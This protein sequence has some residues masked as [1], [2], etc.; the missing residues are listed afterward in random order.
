MPSSYGGFQRS[1]PSGSPAALPILFGFLLLAFFYLA[2]TRRIEFRLEIFGGYVLAT[3][4]YLGTLFEVR[5]GLALMLIAIGISPEIG[6][7]DLADLRAE[8]AIVPAVFLAWVTRMITNREELYPTPLKLPILGYLLVAFLSTLY[9]VSMEETVPRRAAVHFLKVTEYFLMFIMVLNNV[10]TVEQAK[11]LISIMMGASFLSGLY[12][13]F[14]SQTAAPD[15]RLSGPGGEGANILGGYYAFHACL[16]AGLAT[17]AKGKA[18][19]LLIVGTLVVLGFPLMRTASRASLL[20]MIAGLT[21]ISFFGK[22]K[23]LIPMII[24]LLL[25]PM[26]LPQA[27]TDRFLTILALLPMSNEPIPSSLGAKQGAWILAFNRE[28]VNYP[29]FGQ[30]MGKKAL[31]HVDNEYV[32]VLIEVGFVG[33]IFFLAILWRMYKSGRQTY[34]ASRVPLVRGFSLGYTGAFIAMCVHSIAATS[35]TTIRTMEPFMVATGIMGALY[36]LEIL[37]P[38]EDRGKRPHEG[39]E[40]TSPIRAF[41]H[42][43]SARAA[44]RP[45]FPPPR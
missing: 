19:P 6:T 30:G 39:G 2:W 41:H 12:G 5:V 28:I 3:L 45:P 20:S 31:A 24:A 42:R 35:M 43:R 4:C 40:E 18:K 38:L 27:L 25:F 23:L 32:K 1:R 17:H 15:E 7:G 36:Y 16:A 10:R 21:A 26:I 22:G 14:V 37:Q 9:G 34:Q 13:I 29:I 33:L 8:D 11:F 44:H